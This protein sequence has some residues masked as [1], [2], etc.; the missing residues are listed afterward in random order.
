[1]TE[2][3]G[4]G[5]WFVVNE[6]NDEVHGTRGESKDEATTQLCVQLGML[7]GS[8]FDWSYWSKRGYKVRRD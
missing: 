6:S 5:K 2:A 4:T 1:L 7:H 8:N 3:E